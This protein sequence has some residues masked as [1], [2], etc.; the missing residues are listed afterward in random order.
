MIK[1]IRNAISTIKQKKSTPLHIE[2]NLTDFCNLNCKGC[3]HYSPLAPA[4]FEP[5]EDLERAMYHISAIRDGEKIRSVFLIGGETLLYPDLEEAMRMSRRFFP[6]AEILV[7]TNGLLLPKMSE[8]F[9][10][11]CR[12]ERIEI[13]LTRYP[14]KFDYDKVEELCREKGVSVSVFGDRGVANTFFRLPLDP[15]KR[16]KGWLSHFRCIGFGCITIEKGRIFPCSQAACVG[17]LNRRFGTDF[18]WEQGDFIKVE[19]LKSAEQLFNLRDKPIPFC[20]YCKPIECVD[21]GPSKR[22]KEEWVD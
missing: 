10:E 12:R 9:W 22:L 19:D 14:L 5:L 7:F 16:Q 4:E 18:K 3:S 21:Y 17:H 20:S 2:F 11:T 8:T 1:K 6:W 15:E 13:A